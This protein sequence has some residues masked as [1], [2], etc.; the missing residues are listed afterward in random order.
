MSQ[1]NKKQKTFSRFEC[2][3]SAK[4]NFEVP[5]LIQ[6]PDRLSCILN[7]YKLYARYRQLWNTLPLKFKKDVI[8]NIEYPMETVQSLQLKKTFTNN[9]VGLCKNNRCFNLYLLFPY[10]CNDLHKSVDLVCCKE[11]VD[12]I[13][14][15]VYNDDLNQ[16]L[17][18]ACDVSKVLKICN[19]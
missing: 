3:C 19:F 11:F 14:T 7:N 6:T 17:A 9:D 5:L 1:Q 4:N 16:D 13:N 8:R 12:F 10:Y 18:H 2:C 15:H